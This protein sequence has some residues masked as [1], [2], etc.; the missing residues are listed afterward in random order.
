MVAYVISK[1]T[2][3]QVLLNGVTLRAFF[4][5]VFLFFPLKIEPT[6]V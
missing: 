3:A 6:D 1:D 2:D 4:F 5:F